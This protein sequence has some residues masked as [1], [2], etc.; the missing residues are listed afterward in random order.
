MKDRVTIDR[1]GRVVIPKAVRDQLRLSPGDSLKLRSSEDHLML[2]P[3][4]NRS[5][6]VKKEGIWVYRS[7]EPL[8]EASILDVIDSI[9]DERI[10]E[11]Q[12]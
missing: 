8:K 1:S 11:L 7:P 9:R 5:A 10:R 4:R 6:I 12:G 2:S 3:V